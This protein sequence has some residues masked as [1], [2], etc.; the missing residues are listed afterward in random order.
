MLGPLAKR[1]GRTDLR[2]AQASLDHFADL[3]VGLQL[4]CLNVESR[5]VNLLE[6]LECPFSNEP[7]SFAEEAHQKTLDWVMEMQIF[8]NAL[9]LQRFT[10]SNFMMLAG[11]AYPNADLAA[12]ELANEWGIWLFAWDDQCDRTWENSPSPCSTFST[13]SSKS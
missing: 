6:Q 2:V 13:G 11:L 9:A 5:E 7:S 8:D 12:L 1:E 4:P 10:S 3:E